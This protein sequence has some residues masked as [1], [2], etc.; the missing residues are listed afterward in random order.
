MNNKLWVDPPSGWKFGFPKLYDRSTDNPDVVEWI[1]A[2][3][4]PRKLMESYKDHFCYRMW[5][6]V[7]REQIEPE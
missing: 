2:N 6:D 7:P 5:E 1:V 3:G 4:Y